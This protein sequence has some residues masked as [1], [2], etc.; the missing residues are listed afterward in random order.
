MDNTTEYLWY[1]AE[2][3]QQKGP[4]ANDEFTRLVAQGTVTSGTLVWRSGMREWQAYGSLLQGDAAGTG[5]MSCH[6]CGKAFPASELI[7][8]NGTR[9][10]AACKP[11]FVQQFKENAEVTPPMTFRYAGFW[12]RAAAFMLDGILFNIITQLI[13]LPVILFIAGT[14]S[15]YTSVALMAVT[16]LVSFLLGIAY[17][18]W[19]LV[20]YGATPGK[21]ACGLKVIRSD[22]SALSWGRAF[23]RYFANMLSAMILYIGYIMAAIDKTE[24]KALHDSICDTRV[25]YKNK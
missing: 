24:H 12:I 19:P 3:G 14:E 8:F 17:F 5:Q 22:G 2:H 4:V 11:L 25:I 15:V 13:I 1:Y 9:V 23:G 20:K 6:Y 7:D 10:C 16:Y 21:M 18:V